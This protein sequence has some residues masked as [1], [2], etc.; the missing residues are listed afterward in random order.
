MAVSDYRSGLQPLELPRPELEPGEALVEVTA[1]GVCQSDVKVVRGNMPF[2]DALPLPHV[3]GHEICGRVV[4][5][6]PIGEAASGTR[7]IAAVHVPCQQ[8]TR[9]L[10]GDYQLCQGLESLGFS[11]PGGFAGF[12]K[13]PFGNL[14]EVPDELDDVHAAPV[15]CAVG[16]AFRAV[17]TRGGVRLGSSVA[18]VGL[19]GVGIHAAQ[20][21]NLAGAHVVGLDVSAGALDAARKLGLHAE[22]SDDGDIERSVIEKQTQGEGFD[23]VVETVGKR[24][25]LDLACRLIRPGGRLVG[26]GYTVGT[27]LVVPSHR[28]ALD[29]IELVGSRNSKRDELL[30]AL[31]LAATGRLKVVVDRVEPLEKANDVIDDL[32]SGRIAGRAVLRVADSRQL[33][34]R[35]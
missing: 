1:C 16:T 23:V 17:V 10:A 28:F 11:R 33:P 3:P 25:T 31:R 22:R 34:V 20:I 5:S 21:A 12:V 7:V 4:E 13:V 19:G 26:V 32:E 18:V 35:Q 9:C 29:E 2:S 24:A 6:N 27:D 8:C 14:I 15:S 30:T